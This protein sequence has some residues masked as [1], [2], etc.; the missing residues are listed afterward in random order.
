MSAGGSKLAWCMDS[1]FKSF[2]LYLLNTLILDLDPI[3]AIIASDMSH[4]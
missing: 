2:V 4:L 3:G 1:L